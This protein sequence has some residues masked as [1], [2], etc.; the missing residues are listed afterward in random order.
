MS[1]LN[2]LLVTV[3]LGVLSQ[4]LLDLLTTHIA[5]S[6]QTLL[7]LVKDQ[8]MSFHQFLTVHL[9]S[10]VKEDLVHG[11]I[12]SNLTMVGLLDLQT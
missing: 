7:K 1:G 2:I 11:T 5:S 6:I 9:I 4:A 10:I 3:I 12:P 8:L